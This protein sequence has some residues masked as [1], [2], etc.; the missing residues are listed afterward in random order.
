[1]FE[2][3]VFNRWVAENMY[4]Y[5]YIT[6]FPRGVWYLLT[7]QVR[8]I[9]WLIYRQNSNIRRTLVG[10]NIVDNSDVVG[11]SAV[12]AVPTTSSNLDLTHGFNG[13]GKDNYK[14]RRETFY[15]WNSVRLVLKVWRYMGFSNVHLWYVIIQC[16]K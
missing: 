12:G 1:M 5:T 4:D 7:W 13:L 10:S 14:T 3:G 11:A 2:R 16:T 8:I 15:F 6:F 9:I